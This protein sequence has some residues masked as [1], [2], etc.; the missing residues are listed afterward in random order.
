MEKL[1][2]EGQVLSR[3]EGGLRALLD[4][5]AKEGEDDLQSAKRRQVSSQNTKDS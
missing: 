3:Q 4:R 5:I 1:E 2:E